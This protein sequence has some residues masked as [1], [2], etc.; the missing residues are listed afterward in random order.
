[1]I[2]KRFSL[3]AIVL[4]LNLTACK[5][6]DNLSSRNQNVISKKITN[7]DNLLVATKKAYGGWNHLFNKNDVAYTYEYKVPENKADISEERYIFKN[8]VSYGKY[9][10]NQVNALPSMQ[11]EVVQFFDGKETTVT[12][13]NTKIEN[14]AKIK[15]SEFLRRANYFWFVMPYKLTDKGT[16]KENLGTEVINN[17]KYHK[18][19]ITYN[20]EITGKKLN[21]IYI[22]YINDKTKLI[23][24]FYFSLPFLGVNKPVILAKYSYSTIQNQK[25]ATKRIYFLPNKTGNYDTTP[26]ITQTLTNIKFNNGFTVKN[27]QN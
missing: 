21:D 15:G 9:S 13:N 10:R 25:I 22:L 23:D 14:A 3:L 20:A 6:K 11:G 18:I 17:I 1:M 26:S 12:V 2:F 16:I 7:L 19:K 4:F 24:K 5:K 8:E 27:I